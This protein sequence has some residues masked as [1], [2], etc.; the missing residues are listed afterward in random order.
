MDLLSRVRDEIAFEGNVRKV[1]LYRFLMQFQLWWPIWVVYLQI[2]RGFSLTQITF[3]ET[4]FL[5][6]VVLA[7]IPTGTVADRY[8]RR[9]SLML[10]SAMFGAAVFVFGMADSYLVIL[11]SYTVWGLG[12]TFQ[13]GADAAILYDSL[14]QINRADDFERISGRL[15]AV[16]SIAA[17]GAILIGAPIAQATSFTFA[18][19]LS[20]G[21]GLLG[22][23]VAF[24]MRE[25]QFEADESYRHYFQT[26]GA[27]IRDS[28][29]QP[30]LRYVIIFSGL[31]WGATFA[32]LVLQ[33]PF[34]A[35]HDIGTGALGLWQ[36]PVR[37]A[38]IVA[39]LGAYRFV[40]RVGRHNAFFALPVA[41]AISSFALAGIDHAW[42]FIAFITVGLAAGVQQP[43]LARYINERIPSS[44]R[45]TI[46][47]VQNLMGSLTLA[48]LTP[49]GG[50]IS[51]ELGLQA[52]FLTFAVL[53]V[54]VAPAVYML[55][56]RADLA[57][58]VLMPGAPE[59]EA[60]R[61]PVAAS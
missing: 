45:A 17:L 56:R 27:G 49:L 52:A 13:S 23:P 31:I 19:T 1:Y 18:I 50:I 40:A 25:P 10:G 26:L 8:G 36:A 46:L 22:V 47:S 41:L 21:I 29:S 34:L 58:E 7:E 54:A 9:V 32:P 61:E 28:W 12:Q 6:F 33:Q 48:V 3:L 11:L 2:E 37:L 57:T 51:D 4:P 42:A 5:L 53:T 14:K 60:T 43:L 59:H 35:K 55:W 16:N 44:R 15:W 39:A 24:L 20:A 30:A 38:G